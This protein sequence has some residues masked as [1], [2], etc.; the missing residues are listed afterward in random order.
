M[1]T[2]S[3]GGL[4]FDTSRQEQKLHFTFTYVDSTH[5]SYRNQEN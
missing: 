2:N 1:T 4:H 3:V 5:Y